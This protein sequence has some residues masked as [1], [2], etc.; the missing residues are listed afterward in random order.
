MSSRFKF[1]VAA[2]AQ[3]LCHAVLRTAADGAAVSFAEQIQPIFEQSCLPCHNATK[4]E[5]G[6]ILES[7]KDMLEGGDAGA[8]LKPGN[9]RQSLL[10][11]TAA[12]LKKPFM[13][14]EA[15]KA[16]A[17]A[18]TKAETELLERWIQ[19]GAQGQPKA[20]TPIA[21]KPM[22]AKVSS[23]GAVALSPEGRFAAVARGNTV[24][25]YDV[26]TGTKVTSFVPHPDLVGALAFSPDGALLATGSRGEAKLWKRTFDESPRVPEPA[27][28]GPATSPDGAIT[29]ETGPDGGVLL[30][31]AKDGKE[32]ARLTADYTLFAAKAELELRLAGARFEVAFLESEQKTLAEKITKLTA[33]LA[34]V[35]KSRTELQ[36]K[37]ADLDK[38]LS[39]TLQQ[40]ERLMLE[41]D[42]I[43][44]AYT[45]AGRLLEKAA[46]A[47]TTAAGSLATATALLQK[48]AP[49]VKAAAEAALAAAKA[50]ADKTAEAHKAAEAAEKAA[51]EKREAKQKEY[52]E[53][54]K[55]H[56]VAAGAVSSALTLDRNARNYA[57]VL[58]ESNS[59]QAAQ[60]TA[61]EKA[62]AGLKALEAGLV[63]A[64]E[65][66]TSARQPAAESAVFSPDGTV[67]FTRHTGGG[68]KAWNG[69]TGEPLL[70]ADLQP[71]WEL[72]RAIGDATQVDA[73][74]ANRVN[75]LAFSPDGRWLATGAGEPSRSGQIK[76]WA[77]DSG[78]L[79]RELPKPHKD[80]VL[81]LDFS[82]DGKWL[83]SGAADRAVRIW[84]TQ[85]GKMF[86]NMEAHASHVLSV[87]LRGD[88]RRIASAS[89]D[90]SV[91]TWD[92]RLSDVVATFSSF[93]REVNF[94]R[95]L[96]RS[97]ELFATS[98]SPAVKIL[99]EA[100]G[101]TR[102]TTPGFKRFVTAGATA[103]TGALQLVGDAAGVARLLDRDGKV[104]GEWSN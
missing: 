93:T 82:A 47:K 69:K 72:L 102:A 58:A 67:L 81:S 84:E 19:E 7:P 29:A 66:I 18:L 1:A 4:A 3:L 36:P 26:L 78:A 28:G 90:N 89:A 94:V 63:A 39:D 21:W 12:H 96:G 104:I 24:S 46:E 87:S 25:I 6:L 98:G 30:K 86:R 101:E 61:L 103:P 74:L 43:E 91:K 23:V 64:S 10:F 34:A 100:G 75:A 70:H 80:A 56:G 48:A 35:E 33:D 8:A 55:A 54:I 15:N 52:A 65:K 97:D 53:A 88:G 42:S 11:L 77:T 37:R 44:D 60:K 68:L 99:K 5:G 50:E 83:A 92:I 17:P 27:A 2:S 41:R 76:V 45:G 85:T 40:K 38:A 51:K 71:R 31:N 32:I 62:T 95:Y 16:K 79:V 13:P 14:P 73:P 59:E 20:K 9:A 49:E 57:Q 22:P